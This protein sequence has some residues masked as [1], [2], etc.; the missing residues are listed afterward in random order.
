MNTKC[1]ITGTEK[2][3]HQKTIRKKLELTKAQN[4]S[5]VGYAKLSTERLPFQ[6]I[7]YDL[8]FKLQLNIEYVPV[9]V[10]HFVLHHTFKTL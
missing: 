7:V 8:Y 1:S 9:I 5:N 10:L 4:D 2:L 6:D 3:V